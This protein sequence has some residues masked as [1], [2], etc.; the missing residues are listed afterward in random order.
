ML[1]PRRVGKGSARKAWE[2]LPDDAQLHTEIMGA[3]D[4]QKRWRVRERAAGSHLP[5]WKHPATWLNGECWL[6]EVRTNQEI[7]QLPKA[8]PECK[9]GEAAAVK[10]LC[11][12]CYTRLTQPGHFRFL[13][14]HLCKIGLGKLK[15]ESKSEY[16]ARCREMVL[17]SGVYASQ[18]DK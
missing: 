3:I 5:D 18:Q 4:A 2:K 17:R 6:D 13:Y 14:E 7:Q 15:T 10:G 9:C 11:P 1:Y 16:A 12:E 8:G